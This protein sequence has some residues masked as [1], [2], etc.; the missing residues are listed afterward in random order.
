VNPRSGSAPASF[1]FVPATR[2]DRV[3]RA[4][5]TSAHRVIID[6]ED[7]V[8]P[9]AK[10]AART[11]LDGLA[12]EDKALVRVNAMTTSFHAGDLE[13]LRRWG[14]VDGVVLPKVESADDIRNVQMELPSGVPILPII[15]T[16]RGMNRVDEIANAGVDRL[17]FGIV[18]YLADIGARESEAVLTYPRSRLVIASAAAGIGAPID[19]PTLAIRDLEQVERDAM[20]ARAFGF[21]GKLCI[22]PAQVDI[23]NTVFGSS[24]EELAWAR[25]VLDYHERTGEGVFT[26]EGSMIDAP[27]LE[28]ARR[29]LRSAPQDEVEVR[30]I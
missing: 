17:L 24:P 21:G 8:A 13:A 23:V 10:E 16:A 11:N 7:A 5:A 28:R 22:H 20:T 4:L 29:S 15:E 6:L 25:G 26:F 9:E 27:V 19:G 3:P 14:W 2:P 18:D 12:L 1:L 30:G